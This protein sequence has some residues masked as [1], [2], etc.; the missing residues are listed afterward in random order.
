MYRLAGKEDIPEICRLW[1]EAFHEEPTLPSCDCFVAEQDGNIAG[2]LFAMPQKL[3]IKQLHKAVYFYAIATLKAYQG[4]GICRNLMAYAENRIDADCCMLV[5]AS[6]SLFGFYGTLG[7]ETAFYRNK[8][9]SLKGQALSMEAYLQKREQLL[10]M[11]HVVYDDLSYAQKIYGLKFYETTDGICA[12]SEHLTA[13]NLPH[14][15][16]DI[17]CGMI[18]WLTN[19]EPFDNAY[20]GFTLE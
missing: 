14:D 19:E 16:G 5:P 10:T 18:K 6:E 7:Y 3:K 1:R 20:L 12:A 8:T 4:R 11:P 17:P 9:A 13:E 2:M 15:L